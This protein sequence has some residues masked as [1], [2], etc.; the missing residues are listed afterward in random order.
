MLKEQA[1]YAYIHDYYELTHRKQERFPEV[2]RFWLGALSEVRGAQVLNV[3]CGPQFYDYLPRFAAPPRNY[4]GI[5]IN[6]AVADYLAGADNPRLLTAKAAVPAGTETQLLCGD[7][8]DW[9]D[10]L[11]GRFDSILAVGFLAASWGAD[12]ARLAAAL[13]AMLKP[14]GLLVKVTWHGPHRSP[15]E[16]AQK[17][18]YGFDAAE[19]PTPETLVAAIAEAGFRLTAERRLVT[20][21]QAYGWE[22]IQTC[23]FSATEGDSPLQPAVRTGALA[24][25]N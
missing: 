1:P 14:G 10:A 8:L 13:R 22:A 11:T 7:V 3:G 6:R 17:L 24:A 4:V 12:F 25:R 16:T 20:I 2:S 15:E 23:V 18:R 21:P 19:D 5:D 9:T